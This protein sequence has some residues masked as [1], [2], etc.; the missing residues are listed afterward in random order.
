M[1]GTYYIDWIVD[2]LG[3]YRN[4]FFGISIIAFFQLS[5]H[6]SFSQGVVAIVSGALMGIQLICARHILINDPPVTQ[7]SIRT[8]F[9]F[10][11]IIYPVLILQLLSAT[12]MQVIAM[13][14]TVMTGIAI[15]NLLDANYRDI[16]NPGNRD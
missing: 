7:F 15:L 9:V 2:K 11:S 13:L 12:K 1:N 6:L 14:A 8:I 4:I 16:K 10:P 3:K 5:H